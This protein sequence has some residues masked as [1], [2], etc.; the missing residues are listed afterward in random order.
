MFQHIVG[1]PA[2][3]FR[4]AWERP[5]VPWATALLCG[6]CVRSYLWGTGGWDV[7]LARSSDDIV[8]RGEVWRPL[9]YAFLHAS[10]GHI[11][12][13]LSFLVFIGFSLERIVG[14]W[15]MLGLWVASTGFGGL[16]ATFLNPAL[17]SI[18]A[19]G[20]DFGFLAAAAVVGWRWLDLIPTAARARFGGGIAVFTLYA[21]FGGLA[22][23]EVDSWAHFGGLVAGVVYGAQ[24][25][26]VRPGRGWFGLA[27]MGISV[28]ATVAVLLALLAVGVGGWRLLPMTPA[29]AD[30]IVGTR[31]AWW[32]PAW[33]QAGGTGWVEKTAASN[34][35]D[36]SLARAQGLAATGLTTERRGVRQALADAVDEVVGHYREADADAVVARSDVTLDG[37]AGARLQVHWH[38]G[39]GSA[40]SA[41]ATA[42]VPVAMSSVVEVYVRGHYRHVYSWDAPAGLD[43]AAL[44]AASHASLHLT[45]PA[46]LTEA[47][48]QGTDSLRARTLRGRALLDLGRDAEALAGFRLTDPKELLAALGLCSPE[49]SPACAP[50]LL[51]GDGAARADPGLALPGSVAQRAAL[52][53]AHAANHDV[54][55]AAR[56]LAD[57]LLARP[58]DT[59]LTGLTALLTVLPDLP[60]EVTAPAPR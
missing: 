26:P 13:N 15:A 28:A 35:G 9:T 20:G 6:L 27:N 30:G 40:A 17:P 1:T 41:R 31:P 52:I 54:D 11:V 36:G 34:A 37:V 46:A 58:G 56:L 29:E 38:A 22:G 33:T 24:L 19:S 23:K 55:V 51:A 45:D 7:A 50:V 14:P 32:D 47:S 44:E 16:L 12:S 48:A 4:A 53:R 43:L 49:P 57:G 3:D 18:G 2:A 60:S 59:T 39:L 21:F 5:E 42:G 8:L 10:P 25:V